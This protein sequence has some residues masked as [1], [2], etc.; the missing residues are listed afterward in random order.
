MGTVLLQFPPWFHPGVAQMDHLLTC[1]EQLASHK[2][3]VEFR[4]NLWLSESAGTSTLS[5]LRE[6]DIAFVCVDEPQG[7]KS[8]VPPIATTTS[9]QCIV[10][11]HGRKTET[12]E[13]KGIPAT[14]RFD[15]YYT[16]GELAPWAARIK[17]IAAAVSDVHVLF[18]TNNGDQG[19]V[20]ARLMARLL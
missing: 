18:N 11:F 2:V 4:N 5:F 1:K 16:D 14:E 3:A 15:Y 20:N 9:D 13:K 10:R 7:F 19:I 17:E 6:H 12:W 8:S